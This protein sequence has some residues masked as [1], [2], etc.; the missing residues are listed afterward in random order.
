MA[1]SGTLS[2]SD[3]ISVKE[4]EQEWDEIFHGIHQSIDAVAFQDGHVDYFELDQFF[5][6]NKVT[7]LSSPLLKTKRVP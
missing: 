4:H 7:Q 1:A 2:K 6:V 3:A 5:T